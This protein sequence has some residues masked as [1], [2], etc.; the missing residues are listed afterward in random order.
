MGRFAPTGGYLTWN[1]TTSPAGCD[2][3]MYGGG[4]WAIKSNTTCYIR[5]KLNITT[6]AIAGTYYNQT[7]SDWQISIENNS[8]VSDVEHHNVK[9]VIE[10]LPVAGTRSATIRTY[11]IDHFTWLGTNTT[12]YYVYKN[13]TG[14][15]EATEYIAIYNNAEIWSKYYGDKSGTNWTVRTFDIVRTYMDDA[16]G[17]ITFDMVENSHI[18][19]DAHRTVLLKTST[20][21]YNY[22]GYTN[23]SATTLNG[24]NQTLNLPSGYFC[25]LWNRTTFTWNL[26]IS[27][28]G[29]DNK[30]VARWDV[31][32]TKINANKTWVL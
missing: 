13:L 6:S 9:A 3:F 30:A 25:G 32:V 4:D 19:Y 11:G 24:I 27:G 5:Y 20:Y 8:I 31:I 22:T 16:V 2:P 23:S 21:N 28:F 26:W 29:I 17:N 7:G 12:A 15:N 1:H 14:M 10:T 18:N